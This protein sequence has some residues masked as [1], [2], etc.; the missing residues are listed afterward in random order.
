MSLDFSDIKSKFNIKYC[1][2]HFLCLYRKKKDLCSLFFWP[3]FPDH[4]QT[5]L[6]DS[7][8]W[9][10]ALKVLCE[11]TCKQAGLFNVFFSAVHL[12]SI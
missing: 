7:S 2:N 10:V 6:G 12:S 1:D 3:W 9:T 8:Q 11:S 5:D 4:T